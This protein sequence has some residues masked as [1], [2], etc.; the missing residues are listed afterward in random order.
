MKKRHV[1]QITPYLYP[2][3]GGQEIHTYMLSKHLA[4][5]GWKVSIV[6]T[7]FPKGSSYEEQNGVEIY[8][9]LRICNPMYNPFTPTMIPILFNLDVDIYHAH[10]YWNFSTNFAS[11]ASKLKKVPIIITSHGYQPLKS[12]IGKFVRTF[13]LKTLGKFT[14]DNVNYM[15]LYHPQDKSILRSLG[16]SE[17]NIELI[18]NAIDM[19]E[20]DPSIDAI[21]LINRYRLEN[22]KQILFVGRLIQR[23]GCEFIV[24][25]MP[26]ILKEVPNAKLLV[27]GDGPEEDRLKKLIKNLNIDDSVILFG[28]IRPLGT[29]LK[30]IY[31]SSH[32]LVLPSLDECMSRTI[33]EAMSMELPIVTTKNWYSEWLVQPNKEAALLV[34]PRNISMLADA[35]IKILKDEELSKNL[36]EKGKQLIETTYNWKIIAK[37]TIDLYEKCIKRAKK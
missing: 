22:T 10:S 17:E 13:Y 21:D 14:L 29:L 19:D 25:A 27:V 11:F 28:Y 12:F 3:P 34:N 35:I 20:F 33:L 5:L 15:L 1:C 26:Q 7:N 9:T 18:P 16:I 30:K 37:R 23:K 4:K 24:R 32:L 31:K 8:R 2:F 36:S 6:T